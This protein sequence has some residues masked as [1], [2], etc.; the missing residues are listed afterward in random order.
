[1]LSSKTVVITGASSGIGRATAL[2]LATNHHSSLVL[3]ARRQEALEEVAELCRQ[4]G[5]AVLVMPTDVTKEEEVDALAQETIERFGKIDV[6]VNNAAVSLFG[7]FDEIPTQDLRQL[8]EVNLFGYIYGARAAVAQFRQQGHGSL[9]NVSSVVG[10]VGQPYTGGYSLSKFAIRGLSLSLAQEL[11]DEPNIHVGTIYPAVIDTPIFNQAG[12]YYGKEVQAPKPRI[13]ADQVAKTIIS[14][15]KH[16]KEEAI[17]G[18]MGKIMRLARSVAPTV[19]DKRYRKMIAD[20]H[21]RDE[22][23]DPTTGNLYEPMTQWNKVSGG[24]KDSNQPDFVLPNRWL[25]VAGTALLGA[26]ITVMLIRSRD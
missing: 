4:Q 26:A 7:R 10:L 9:I 20:G 11:A 22:P 21:F 16:P 2:A 18:G 1:M 25:T 24:W 17:V 19:F 13:K 23:A 14:M 12:N 3:A 15:I 5:S 8:L 6:W